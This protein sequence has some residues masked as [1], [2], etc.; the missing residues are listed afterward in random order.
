MRSL[1]LVLFSLVLSL[2]LHS[3]EAKSQFEANSLLLISID[4]FGQQ[5]WETYKAPVLH[6]LAQGGVRALS[7]QPVFPTKTFP[8]HYSIAT[9]LYPANHGIVENNIY[10]AD[11]DAVFRMSKPEEVTNSRW[12][13]GEP[14][15]VTAEKQGVKTGT[16]FFPGTEAA[17]KGVRPGLWQAYDGSISNTDRV[18]SVLAWLDLPAEQRPQFLT[19]YFSSVD[20]AGHAYGPE[21]K[22][23]ADAIAD[24]DQALA[25][26]VKGLEQRGLQH[27]INLMLVSDHGMAKVPQQQVIVL[28]QLFDQKKAALVLWTPEIV[29]I[30]PKKNELEAI[31]QQ[32]KHS[33]PPQAKVYKKADLPER[34]FYQNSKRIAPILVVPEA[35]WRLMQQHK[36]K[37]WLEK[38]GRSAVTGSHGY[39]NNSPAMQA[40][41]VGHGPAFAAGSQIPAF[42][43]IE[44]YNLM[45]RI[46]GIQPAPND[47]NPDWVQSVYQAEPK[48]N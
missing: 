11:F 45:C 26:L 12:W 41:F 8:N 33:L 48:K 18:N 34:W 22:Q 10:D 5:Y 24:V 40:I 31:Y 7:M 35:G 14:I 30:F 43:N 9:G 17:I 27:S 29:S 1:F 19:L 42:S 44:L 15:W 46:L 21:S 6:Q 16:Y 39:D 23:V 32:L 25:L 36:Q 28:D 38:P 3:A 47:G 37:E 20:D 2:D 13:L 4:G